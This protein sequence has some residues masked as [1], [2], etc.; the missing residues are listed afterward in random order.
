MLNPSKLLEF[1]NPIVSVSKIGIKF[2]FKERTK[3]REELK[4]VEINFMYLITFRNFPPIR[5]QM[6]WILKCEER[7][8]S[9]TKK[10][11]PKLHSRVCLCKIGQSDSKVKPKQKKRSEQSKL[12]GNRCEA[13]RKLRISRNHRN[14]IPNL[15]RNISTRREK[16]P[17]LI[18]KFLGVRKNI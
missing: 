13:R 17:Q 7:T 16:I 2:S 11:D 14:Q 12:L 1:D 4:R 6:R 5:F 10:W 8:L 18:K 9:D 15:W 3:S